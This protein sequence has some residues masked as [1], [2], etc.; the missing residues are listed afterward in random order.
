MFCFMKQV[1]SV[2]K[3]SSQC[4]LHHKTYVKLCKR[5]LVKVRI[6]LTPARAMLRNS[7]SRDT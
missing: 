3:A 5:K 1:E 7:H 2:T 6:C 4:L